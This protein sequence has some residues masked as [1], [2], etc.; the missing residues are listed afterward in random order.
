MT[1]QET[2]ELA[3]EVLKSATPKYTRQRKDQ[4]TLGGALDYWKL[5]QHQRLKAIKALEEA[6]TQE[7]GEQD[8]LAYREAASLAKWL[9]NKHFAHED[10][11]ASGRVVW[12]LCDTTAGVISQIDNMVCKLVREQEQD[13]NVCARCGGIVFDPVIKQEQGEP[14]ALVIDGVLVKSKLPEKYTGHLYTTPQQRTWVGLTDE[15][16]KNIFLKWY[17]KHWAYTEQ[18]QSVMDS[19][20]AR[21]KELNT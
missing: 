6:L 21:L 2:F 4:K 5:E 7:H 9:F 1:N 16:R 18:V 20:E 19:V 15:E 3:L 8:T 10:H 11:Y 12:G 13:G 14:V 17:G